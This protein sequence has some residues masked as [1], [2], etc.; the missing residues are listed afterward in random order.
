MK[1]IIFAIFVF[2]LP[3]S[4][5]AA[6]ECETEADC[7][8]GMKCSDSTCKIDPSKYSTYAAVTVNKGENS[9]NALGSNRI[10]VE[11]PA[12]DLVLGQISVE[13]VHGGADGKYYLFKELNLKTIV[14]STKVQASDIKL[15]Y[16]ANGNGAFDSSEEVVA[17][18]VSEQ[19]NRPQLVFDQTKA[20][21]EMNK[22]ENF[23]VVGS[24]TVDAE[25]NTVWEFGIEF[26]PYSTTNEPLADISNAGD[27]V[28]ASVP[29]SVSLPM[30]GF[31]PDTGHFLLASGK[32]FPEAPVWMDMNDTHTI[33]HLRAKALD[34]DNEVKALNFRLEGTAVSYGN[35]VKRI[36]VYSDDNN[37]G[38][39]DSKLAEFIPEALSSQALLS[40]PSGTVSL[41]KGEEMFMVVEAELEFY[42]G[43]VTQFYI[44]KNGD[45]QLSAPETVVGVT[46]STEDFRYDCDETDDGCRLDPSKTP[47][48]DDDGGCALIIFD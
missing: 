31:E 24:F 13:A 39:G 42:S 48:S 38:K 30:F 2:V 12:T 17:T 34:K 37:D 35:G 14:S 32:Y 33:M 23:L 1:K 10:Y 19:I 21:Y 22:V 28:L 16:D 36:T 11:Y 41:K 15:V 44:S 40:F 7:S 43:Q 29:Q 3:L 27:V 9:P 6:W 26:N 4:V 45:V 18:D 46:I 25:L 47:V 20:A 5:F 8:K